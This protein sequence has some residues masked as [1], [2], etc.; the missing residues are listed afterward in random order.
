MTRNFSAF[1]VACLTPN[2]GWKL[3]SF[4]YYAA[5][6]LVGSGLTSGDLD[7]HVRSLAHELRK[8][9]KRGVEHGHSS[10]ART[11]KTPTDGVDE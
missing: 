1:V 7:G 11:A 6:Y 4:E 9:Y 2:F 3:Q 8:E 10:Q 5:H